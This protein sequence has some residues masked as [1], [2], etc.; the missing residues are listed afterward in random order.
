MPYRPTPIDTSEV[1]LPAHLA[2]LLEL[3]AANVHEAWA[4]TKVDQ[5]WRYGPRQDPDKKEHPS[6][7]PFG[8]LS[9]TEKDLDRASACE[10]LKT[11][12]KLGYRVL[13]AA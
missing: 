12:T 3:L 6:L 4:R 5:G 11:M 2:E 7:V 1:M 9:E 8:D 10:V 13:P